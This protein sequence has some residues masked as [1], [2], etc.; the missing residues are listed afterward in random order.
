MD[1]VPSTVD[2]RDFIGEKLQEIEHARNGDDDRITQY[3]ERLIRR[4]ERDPMEMNGEAGGENGEVKIN[5]GE[6]GQAKGN[7]EKVEF[8]HAKIIGAGR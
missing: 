5:S 8:F 7:A 1:R 2:P 6:A 3:F 4:R